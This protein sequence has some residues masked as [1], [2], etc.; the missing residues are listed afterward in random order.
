MKIKTE[1][2]DGLINSLENEIANFN[3]TNH[4]CTE[5]SL[6]QLKRK[7]ESAYRL[8]ADD[9]IV[10]E[11]SVFVSSGDNQ[12]S[13]RFSN[14]VIEGTFEIIN[15]KYDFQPAHEQW[16]DYYTFDFDIRLNIKDAYSYSEMSNETKFKPTKFEEWLCY[17]NVFSQLEKEA[18]FNEDRMSLDYFVL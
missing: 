14:N 16:E 10:K 9:V 2:L 13:F 5:Y 1:N 3:V 15:F 6:K 12:F 4:L 11:T 8:K 18:E 17:V 7:L